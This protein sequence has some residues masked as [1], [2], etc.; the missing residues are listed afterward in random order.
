MGRA[1]GAGRDSAR[2]P[3]RPRRGGRRRRVQ[4]RG[5]AGPVPALWPVVSGPVEDVRGGLRVEPGQLPDGVR[6]EVIADTVVAGDGPE[7]IGG[8]SRIEIGE[9]ASGLQP[10]VIVNRV[11][12]G[13]HPERVGGGGP[14][15]FRQPASRLQPDI[16]ID[17]VVTGNR[18]ERL[19][20]G[21]RIV[22]GELPG[23]GQA[24]D[25]AVEVHG[26]AGFLCGSVDGLRGWPST[27]RP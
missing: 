10:D 21:L 9:P 23:E 15:D 12:A 22:F 7:G 17:R 13:N 3:W 1:I 24:V 6:A 2:R 19:G 8:G 11:V 14:I 5:P 4:H 18:P 20:T 27:R 25:I 26:F 16:I